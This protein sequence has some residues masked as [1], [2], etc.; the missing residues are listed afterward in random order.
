MS[1][2]D[3]DPRRWG[4][5]GTWTH[6]T[7]DEALARCPS[8][9]RRFFHELFAT[10]PKVEA[11]VAFMR[12]S[13]QPR[14]GYAM[15]VLDRGG[16]SV[17]IDADLGYIVVVEAAGIAEYGDWHGDMVPVALSHV[18]ELVVTEGGTTERADA[19]ATP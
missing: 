13:E 5:T 17:Q 9:A 6:E 2:A 10:F 14:D 19:E 11:G 16:F 15:F 3:F 7:K 18:A 8:F 12:W 4:K 1:E